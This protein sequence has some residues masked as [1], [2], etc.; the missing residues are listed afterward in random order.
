MTVLMRGRLV[1]VAS[2]VA[3]LFLFAARPSAEIMVDEPPP[4]ILSSPPATATDA[5]K[6]PDRPAPLLGL[7][8]SLATLQALDFASTRTAL[9]AGGVE[10]NP[11]VAPLL[12]SPIGF[13]ALK[14]GITG[15]TI[16]VSERL[17]KKNRRAAVLTMIGLN[18]GY[19]AVVG[20]NYRVAASQRR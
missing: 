14:A 15:A 3:V 6:T 18:A 5:A 16:Y 11:L 17:W 4:T 8:V 20:H 13:L 10:G 9:N 1:W 7:Y 12:A 19:A 2:I